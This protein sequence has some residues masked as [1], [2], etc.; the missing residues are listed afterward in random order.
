MC[1]KKKTSQG[2]KID[3]RKVPGLPVDE[4]FSKAIDIFIEECSKTLD[5]QKVETSIKKITIEWW[6]DIAPSP[7]TGVLNTVVVYCDQIYSGLT[8]GNLC[9]VAWRGKL[10]R[11]AFAHEILH[12]VGQD[13][14]NDSDG[15]HNNRQLWD[16]ELLI[17]QKL[18]N[19]NL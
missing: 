3:R 18:T 15:D 4:D 5:R 1:F 17:N 2:I 12:V 9:R 11:S 14:L 8:T 13:V 6:N 10:Y 19:I 16:I 7:S